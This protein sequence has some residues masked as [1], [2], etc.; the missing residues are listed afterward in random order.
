MSD[1]VYSVP[2]IAVPGLKIA[3]QI[4]IGDGGTPLIAY[5]AAV[6]STIDTHD[7]N[8]LLD[9]ISSA[10]ARQKAIHDLPLSKLR[11]VQNLDKREKISRDLALASKTAAEEAQK[12]RGERVREVPM[13]QAALTQI[14]QL[15]NALAETEAII[16]HDRLRIPYL[17]AVIDG[18]PPPD[19]FPEL[20]AERE[21]QPPRIMAAE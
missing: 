2:A 13:A 6:D 7:L 19:L 1:P 3:Y 14:T 10:A 18:R 15:S 11:L 9:R 21:Y 5:E 8:E 16:N 17:E 4:Q 20:K 12:R